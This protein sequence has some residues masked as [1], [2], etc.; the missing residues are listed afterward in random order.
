[1][2][3]KDLK[4]LVEHYKAVAYEVSSLKRERQ[5]LQDKSNKLATSNNELVTENDELIKQNQEHVEE[6]K[7]YQL[8]TTLNSRLSDKLERYLAEN[9]TLL[10]KIEVL[11]QLNK[12]LKDKR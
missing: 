11:E 4:V 5:F 3:K 1:M 9:K 10:A 8:G 6:I 2:N 12:N 7:Q